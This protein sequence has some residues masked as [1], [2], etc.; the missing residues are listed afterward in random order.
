M[1]KDPRVESAISH[2]APRFISNGVLLADFE[3]VT[4]GVDR[5]EDWCSA[6]SARAAFHESLGSEALEQGYKLSAGEHLSRAAVYYHFAKFVFVHDLDQMRTAHMKAVE[7]R[8]LALPHLRPPG[9]RVEIPYEGGH[10]A[11]ILRRPRGGT[12]P[13]VVIMVP[14]LDSAKEE[15]EA[16]EL[17]FLARGMAT[18]M[19]DGPGQGEAEY[20]FPIRGD[21]EVA[22]QSMVDWVFGRN[23]IDAARIGLWGVSLGGYYAP[24]AVA[25]EKRI[26][27][28]IGLAGPYDWEEIWE[29]LPELT[30]EAFRVRSHKRTQDEARQHARTLTLKGVAKRIECPLF[31]V[32]GKLDRLVPWQHAQRIADEAKGPVELLVVE[33]GNHI[34]NNRPYRYRLKTA[35]WMAAQLCL[36]R[37]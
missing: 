35:D 21:F 9:E 19:V 20:E 1:A 36:P 27:A 13:P 25:F 5:R 14:G 2:W 26:R 16:Y 6:W 7:C 12:R 10:L 34:A 37:V 23:D 33:D 17:P 8:R 18:L 15:M 11:G 22:A 3:E 32:A 30:R 24:R 31:L 4:A 29:G 28:C